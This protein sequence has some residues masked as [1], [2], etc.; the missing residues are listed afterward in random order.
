MKKNGFTLI[1]LLAV[2]TVLGLISLV[3]VS[4]ITGTLKSY[5]NTLYE[6]QINNIE[7]AARLWASDN[8]L[9]LPNDDSST[10]VCEYV[11]YNNCSDNY[12]KLVITLSELQKSGYLDTD[13]KNAKT[14]KTFENININ[15]IKKGKKIIYEVNDTENES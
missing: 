14:K 13:L 9:K 15:I 4:T 1:E 3:T 10:E 8:M 2:L 7:A 5:K 12:Y 11:N 6:N